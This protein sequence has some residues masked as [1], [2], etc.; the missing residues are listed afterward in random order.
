VFLRRG[1]GRMRFGW[2]LDF[3]GCGAVMSLFGVGG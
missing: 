1:L 3:A 2:F